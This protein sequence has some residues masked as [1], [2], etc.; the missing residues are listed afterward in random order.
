MGC[1]SLREGNAEKDRAEIEVEMWEGVLFG[2]IEI[3]IRVEEGVGDR[4]VFLSISREVRSNIRVEAI[5]VDWD[6]SRG[7]YSFGEFN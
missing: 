3:A 1:G 7:S 5:V 2:L 6:L 4:S